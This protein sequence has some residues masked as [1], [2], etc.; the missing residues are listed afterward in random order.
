M[1]ADP[2]TARADHRGDVLQRQECH[3]LKE[4]SDRRVGVDSVLRRV[5]QFRT[6]GHEERQAVADLRGILFL[7]RA[8]VIVMVAVVVLQNT[9]DRHLPQ[10]FIDLLSGELLL[11]L[12][13]NLIG[14]VPLAQLEREQ[15]IDLILVQ[16]LAQPPVFGVRG[17]D[18]AQFVLHV[19]RD[20]ACQF[21]ILFL[22]RFSFIF[23]DRFFFIPIYF[24]HSLLLSLNYP[25][26]GYVQ[27]SLL[28]IPGPLP[29][30]LFQP[31]FP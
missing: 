29:P 2:V 22:Q 1:H 4:R 11:V 18:A 3:T 28:L 9:V 23:G 8:V 26:P 31:R 7:R 6:A 17:L 10:Q 21:G 12:L 15:D 24:G 5:E 19:V 27:E 13:I 20:L 16:D 30:V 14:G 25:L